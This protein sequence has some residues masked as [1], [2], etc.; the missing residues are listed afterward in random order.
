VA[1]R[2]LPRPVLCPVS[3]PLPVELGDSAFTLCSPPTLA[4]CIPPV[5]KKASPSSPLPPISSG[6]PPCE[7]FSSQLRAGEI[8]REKDRAV[9]AKIASAIC[10]P[11]GKTK[12]QLTHRN[13][14]VSTYAKLAAEARAVVRKSQPSKRRAAGRD[15]LRGIGV[16]PGG[17][18]SGAR[19]DAAQT[20]RSAAIS[21]AYLLSIANIGP[22]SPPY[23][24]VFTWRIELTCGSPFGRLL[25][26]CVS[27]L[28]F[29]V[30]ILVV[31]RSL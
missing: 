22:S 15:A 24:S 7:W 30:C 14:R 2:L 3:L 9:L 18:Q 11:A 21:V 27:V 6:D 26:S 16:E 1:R 13:G 4:V 10:L 5:G 20:S 17:G 23:W 29:I 28:T 31:I 25:P 8:D 12:F 19:G